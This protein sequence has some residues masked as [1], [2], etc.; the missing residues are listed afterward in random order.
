MIRRQPQLESALLG[1]LAADPANRSL[2]LELWSGRGGEEARGWQSRLT[3]SLVDA[4]RYGEARDAWARFSGISARP[5]QL[6]DP[7]FTGQSLPPFGWTL[8]SGPGGVAEPEGGGRLHILYYGRDNLVLASQ[9]MTLPPGRYLL[10]MQ[11]S[12]ASPTAKALSWSVRC[13]PSSGPIAS[14]AIAGSG[15]LSVPFAV[16]S[17]GCEAQRLELAGTA[18]EFPEK[19][20]LAISKLRLERR[21]A[22]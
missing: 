14:T 4:R 2:I 22:L 13:L 3:N 21:G 20:D 9:L 5:D 19:A 15:T 7:E 17:S 8:V 12:G 18:P 1:A 11:V 6:L 10:S 16:P